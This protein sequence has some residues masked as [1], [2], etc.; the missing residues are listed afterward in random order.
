MTPSFLCAMFLF[1]RKKLTLASI[2]LAAWVFSP[3]L[4][5]SAALSGAEL[6][7]TPDGKVSVKGVKVFQ[8]A[9]SNFYARVYWGDVFLRLT[10]VTNDS[11]KIIKKYGEHSTVNEIKE[12]D[13]LDIE[14]KF[15]SSSD[16]FIITASYIK[17][18]SLEKQSLETS[19]TVL[20][21]NASADEFTMKTH[22]GNII[23]VTTAAVDMKRG[24]IP[25]TAAQ[26]LPGEKVTLARGTYDY[27]SDTLYADTVQIHQNRGVFYPR[28]FSG[29]ITAIPGSSLP[30][31]IA[32]KAEGKDYTVKLS[33]NTSLLNRNREAVVFS[34]FLVGDSVRFYGAIR[35][36]NLSVID[37]I[38]ILRNMSL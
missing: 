8:K 20:Y 18:F 2:F 19:G 37:N 10:V 12:G 27:S 5:A 14:G 34:R 21:S 11:T 9:G 22:K 6:H 25:V 28:N 24:I 29:K 3:F 15:P 16:T 36:D 1:M 38:L 35:E 23:K 30:L 32:V 26:L 13:M 4:F 17:N 33:Q 31:D 7:I